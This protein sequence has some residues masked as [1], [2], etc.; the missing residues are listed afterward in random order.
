MTIVHADGRREDFA[1]THQQAI[2]FARLAAK[3][4]GVGESQSVKFDSDLAKRDIAGETDVKATRKKTA[5]A[6]A[7][8]APGA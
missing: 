7:E 3:D 4:F 6:T 5:R 8:P 1:L 2:T